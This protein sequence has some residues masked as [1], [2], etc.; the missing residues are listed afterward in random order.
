[1]LQIVSYF[2]K[3]LGTWHTRAVQPQVPVPKTGSA[4]ISWLSILTSVVV[5]AGCEAPLELGSVEEQRAKPIQRTDRYQ[6]AAFNGTATAVVGNQGVIVYSPDQGET[7]KRHTLEGWPALI[8]VAACPNGNFAVLAYNR[9]VYLSSDNG[10]SWQAKP[11]TTEETP[12]AITCTPTNNLWVVG[13]FTF[14]WSS[15]DM[16]DTWSETTR[17]EDSIFTSVQFI[18]ENIGYVTGEFGVFLKT[19]DGGENWE[20]MA[21]FPNDFY[22]QAA[23]F[24]SESEGWATGLGGKILFTNDGGRS[25]T[26]QVTNVPV[27]IYG[28]TEIDGQ[29]YVAGGEG[30]LLQLAGNEWKPVPHDK[31]LRLYIRALAGVGDRLLVGGINGTLHLIQLN[32]A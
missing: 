9:T 20:S 5:L 10:E 22:S 15:K 19:T 16:G 13:S 31:P 18:D 11:I 4:L 2:S 6:A 29:V 3:L 28:I 32:G 23:H 7:W 21:P 12:Q 14:M 26:E 27:P 17:D 24:R 1:M 30:T 25:W 8:D